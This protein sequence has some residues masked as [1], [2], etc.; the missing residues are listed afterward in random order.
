M[1]QAIQNALPGRGQGPGHPEEATSVQAEGP[2][3]GTMAGGR[4]WKLSGD[5]EVQTWPEP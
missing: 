2:E 1:A 5:L 3:G 4:E